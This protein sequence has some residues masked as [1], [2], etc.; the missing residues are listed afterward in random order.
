LKYDVE[1]IYPSFSPNDAC[2]ISSL[3]KYCRSVQTIEIKPVLAKIRCLSSLFTKEPLT[4]QYFYSKEIS[5]VIRKTEFDMVLV[6]C[7]SMASYVTDVKKPKIIDYIDVDYDKWRMYSERSHIPKSLIYYREYIKLKE[8]EEKINFQFDHSIV[9]SENEKNL[10]PKKS[11]ITVVPNGIDLQKFSPVEEYTKNSLVFSGAMNYFANVDGVLYFYE[12][13]LP[14]IKNKA[15]DVQFTIA[16]MNPVRKIRKLASKDIIVT[17]YVPDIRSYVAH[18]AVCV[19]PLR[20]AKG[21]QNKV[22]EAMAMEVPVVATTAANRGIGARDKKEI[23]LADS[24]AE[25]AQATLALLMN[26]GL[27]K[28]IATNAK[29]FVL[30]NFSW[31]A[32]LRKL[33]DVIV[34]VMA[35]STR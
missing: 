18:A 4:K 28:E 7:S 6:D 16:G 9:V 10:L 13:I 15:R 20:I 31:E 25:F 34:R 2:H 23:L 30:K 3:E 19:V 12:Q 22:L 35:S 29:Q 11:H 26:V 14:L 5:D 27:R 24:P 17:G 32:H 21:V 1:L 8:F 33:D